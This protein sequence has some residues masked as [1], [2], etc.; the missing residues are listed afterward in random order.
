MSNELAFNASHFVPDVTPTN[1]IKYPKALTDLRV[2]LNSKDHGYEGAGSLTAL[3]INRAAC[4]GNFFM[5]MDSHEEAHDFAT[6]LFDNHGR[7]QAAL[8]NDEY[9]KGLGTFGEELN[10]GN[11]V[12]ITGI[13]VKEKVRIG[14]MM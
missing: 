8:L 6:A 4:S 10:R 3:K 5:I 12:L 2:T 7:I 13:D 14:T 1:N 11:M 9:K